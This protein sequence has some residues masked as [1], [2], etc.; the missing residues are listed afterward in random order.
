[1]AVKNPISLVP[2]LLAR[3]C[4]SSLAEPF[5]ARR[6]TQAEGA[7]S[8]PSIRPRHLLPADNNILP[9]HPIRRNETVAYIRIVPDELLHLSRILH[10]ED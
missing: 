6:Q 3:A 8:S 2:D 4:A 7:R 9:P 1:M 10:P 5:P